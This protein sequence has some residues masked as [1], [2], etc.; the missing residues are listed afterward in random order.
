[1]SRS[2]LLHAKFPTISGR[3][4]DSLYYGC[5]V[6][7]LY[8]NVHEEY[9]GNVLNKDMIHKYVMRNTYNFNKYSMLE[10]YPKERNKK[11]A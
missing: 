3:S 10:V 7:I 4:M 2:A 1:M 11:N 5:G 8:D 6:E 9:L